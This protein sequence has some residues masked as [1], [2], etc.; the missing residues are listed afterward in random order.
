MPTSQKSGT[1]GSR[2][3]ALKKRKKSWAG[4]WLASR[5]SKPVIMVVAFMVL[6]AGALLWATAATTS[7][8]LWTNSTVPKV[9]SSSDT[10][11]LELGLKFRAQVAGYVTGVRFYKGAGNTGTHTGN[12][13]DTSGHLL[14]SVKFANETGTGWQTASF[15]NPVSIAAGVTYIVS[16]NAPNGHYSLNANYFST[17]SH[18]RNDLTA[19]QNTA[20]SPNGVIVASAGDSTFPTGSGNG[21][22]YWV[23]LVFTT[24]LISSQP[25][26]AA[27]TNLS[28]NVQTNSIVL[29]WT[30]S[31][32][33]NAISQYAIY[34]D[35][36]KLTTVAG[37]TLTY[38]DSNVTAGTTYS[39]Q[40][41]AID[42]TG[43]ASALST[44][45]SATMPSSGGT[46][47]GTTGSTTCPLP[48]YPSPKCTGVPAGTTFTKTV[49]GD[50]TA[51]TTGEVL[52]SV[53]ITGNLTIAAANVTV[54]NSQV[55]GTIDNEVGASHYG[56][57]TVADT[58]IGPATGCISLPG[59]GES[60]YTA[61]RVLIRGHDDGF[62]MGADNVTVTDSYAHL[63][64]NP[65]SIAPPDGS[66]SDGFQN[67]CRNSKGDSTPCFGLVFTHNTIDEHD[68]AGNAG[69][70][71][72]SNP[73]G[74][75]FGT[76]NVSDNMFWGGGYTMSMQ[77]DT[78]SVWTVHNNRVVNK[79]W[80]YGPAETIGTCAQQDW[81]GNSLVTIDSDYNI[82]G[83]VAALPCI[84]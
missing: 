69:I 49:N 46:G 72:G 7:Y 81:S 59:I 24:K 48:A 5:S 83:T 66:H 50:Y 84:N 64:W 53:H 13:W 23:D 18:S 27:P 11:P 65:P 22:N 76:V 15:T 47:G 39:Y 9:I 40:V 79:G 67:Y 74:T 30:A 8:S 21:A 78:G 70:N 12:L 38:T 14:A 17:K 60:N 44:A 4:S 43:A 25:A 45:V 33:T 68:I 37:A 6:G 1:S 51:S 63:C 28:A 82:T 61:S 29:N 2:K 57:F 71:A 19:P 3:T 55:D 36:N 62:R 26:P 32:S 42:N 73:D 58:T 10:R 41:Q 77:W 34:R 20:T 54:K 16:Y 52:D 31:A 35:G 75:Q 56:P 80:Q